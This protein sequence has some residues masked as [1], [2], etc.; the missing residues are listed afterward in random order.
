V[1]AGAFD[2][3]G[4]LADSLLAPPLP[5]GLSEG[6][7]FDA[8]R[9]LTTLAALRGRP[10]RAIELDPRSG[11]GV[12]FFLPN[13]QVATLPRQVLPDAIALSQYAAVGGS[14]DSILAI[15]ARLADKLSSLVPSGALQ[16]YMAGALLRPLSLAAPVVGPSPAVQ[17][18]PTSDMFVLALKAYAENDIPRTRRY[19]DS[20]QTLH[21]DYPPGEITM[22]VVYGEAWLRSEIGDAAGAA[23]QLD[24]GLRGLSAAPPNS[25]KRYDVV[26]ALVRAMALRADLAHRTHEPALAKRWADAVLLLWGNG[27]AITA[28]TVARMRQL[29]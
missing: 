11:E 15:K 4:A 6:A 2:K 14:A 28:P 12:S 19:L 25:L 9:S 18:G 5:N 27:D 29:H 20:L 17:L 26:A 1:K 22:D 24:R 7:R 13:G 10:S 23:Q 16:S 8:R 3:A 21:E